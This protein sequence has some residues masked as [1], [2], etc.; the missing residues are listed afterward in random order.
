MDKQ[1]MIVLV[2]KYLN[3][4]ATPGERTFVEAW[5]REMDADCPIESVLTADEIEQFEQEMLVNIRQR[6]HRTASPLAH[7]QAT[8]AS[9][10][11]PV[12]PIHSVRPLRYIRP[13][14]A[15]AVLIFIISGSYILYRHISRNEPEYATLYT[16][17]GKIKKVTLGDGTSIWL[18]AASHL[19]FPKTFAK[20]GP[21]E[22]FLEGEAYFEVAK[23]MQHPFLV[24]TRD[25]TTKV[26]GTKFN[27]KAYTGLPGIEVTLLEGKVMLSV[28]STSDR[29]ED[30]L[31]LD[32]NQKG[33]FAANASNAAGDQQLTADRQ[34]TAD[35]PSPTTTQPTSD[36][37]NL[38]TATASGTH[39]PT[40]SC[41]AS[42]LSRQADPVAEDDAA[43]RNGK[44]VFHNVTLTSVTNTLARKYNINIQSDPT[45]LGQC[46]TVTIDANRSAEEALVEVTSQLKHTNEKIYR[47][48]GDHAQYR[49]EGNI[50]YIE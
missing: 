22:V 17:P 13:L 49:K 44:L 23:D 11:A 25:L 18:N 28:P 20:S 4:K 37:T 6:I 1:E 40:A 43:W 42:V 10:P 45:L 48:Y 31:Y 39:H 14:V 15:A 27:V 34:N 26:L 50:Y 3:G 9:S 19:K 8:P 33:F 5:Y 24:H 21:R 41:I 16:Q 30:T 36:N 38:A 29:K 46:I 2:R 32:P 12:H 7:P 47:L 35:S